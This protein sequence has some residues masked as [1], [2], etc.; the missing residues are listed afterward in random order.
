MNDVVTPSDCLSNEHVDLSQLQNRFLDEKFGFPSCFA[1]FR[2]S[3]CNLSED[4]RA[5][6]PWDRLRLSGQFPSELA[7]V[8]IV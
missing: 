8:A 6:L 7:Y 3:V 4:L 5:V 1:S 2:A